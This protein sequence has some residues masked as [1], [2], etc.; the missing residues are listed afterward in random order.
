MLV[1]TIPL[2]ATLLV[3]HRKAKKANAETYQHPIRLLGVGKFAKE[4][5]WYLDVV[6]I[7]LL[8][9]FLALI[10]VPFTIAG[11]TA[12]QWKT[13][14]ILA[15]LII[16]LICLPLFVIWERSYARYPMVPFK[17]SGCGSF[18]EQSL[19]RCSCSRTAL[20][21]ALSA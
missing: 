7:L 1:C 5:F 6:G 12:E 14:K 4:L 3:G 15:P 13:A 11:A 20:F 19:I 16:G 17:V 8:I 9:A 10:L 21:G 18:L 2:F